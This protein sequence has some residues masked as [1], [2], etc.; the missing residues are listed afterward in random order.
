[1]FPSEDRVLRYFLVTRL[2][3]DRG[4]GPPMAEFSVVPWGHRRRLAPT[5]WW[6]ASLYWAVVHQL[7]HKLAVSQLV[8][9]VVH[10]S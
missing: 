1:M 5:G 2:V 9:K 6:V 8:K 4:M 7:V 3:Y 10:G